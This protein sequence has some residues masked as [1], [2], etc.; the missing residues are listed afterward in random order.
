MLK[1]KISLNL[2]FSFTKVML[3]MKY[4]IERWYPVIN[5]SSVYPKPV[6]CIKPNIKFSQISNDLIIIKIEGTNS[7]YDGKYIKGILYKSF[8][9][10]EDLE[11]DMYEIYMLAE[12]HSYPSCNGSCEIWIK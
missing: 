7:I 5:G 10:K 12:W 3:S 11:N 1:H 9:Y 4:K 2:I 8:D 6:I